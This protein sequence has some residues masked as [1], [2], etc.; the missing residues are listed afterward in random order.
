MEGMGELHL[1]IKVDRLKREFNVEVSV[2]KPQVAYKEAITKEVEVEGKYIKQSGG[3]GQYGHIWLRLIPLERGKGIEFEDDITGG[4]VPKEYVPAVEKGVHEAVANGVIAGFPVVDVK[5]VAYD[6]SYHDVDSSEIAFKIAG[7]MA[8]KDGVRKASPVLLE[9]IMKV[10]AITPEEYMGDVMGDLNARRGQIQGM[11]DRSNAK[12]IGAQVPLSEMFGYATTL[13]SMTQGRAS[14]SM[15]FDHYEP[16]PKNIQ[17]TIVGIAV[18][19]K[20]KGR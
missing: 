20:A 5:V 13:R 9:P 17:E 7:I 16:V 11:E 2:G 3:R 18:A 6:G 15:E 19:E 4:V 1:E 14:Y 12:V 8:F 10:E